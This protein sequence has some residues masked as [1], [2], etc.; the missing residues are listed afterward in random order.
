MKAVVAAFNQEK[1]LVGA[2]SVITNIRMDLFEALTW[3]LFPVSGVVPSSVRII[4]NLAVSRSSGDTAHSGER[5][6]ILSEGWE[7]GWGEWTECGPR[8]PVGEHYGP[9]HLE[10]VLRAVQVGAELDGVEVV[11]DLLALARHLAPHHVR[12]HVRLNQVG[13]PQVR[14]AAHLLVDSRYYYRY[15]ARSAEVEPPR[16]WLK[17]R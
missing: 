1:A 2:F 12:R 3:I 6:S 13:G 7:R 9:V 14:H 16:T 4:S 11:G 15:T 10:E 8:S 5:S 17:V